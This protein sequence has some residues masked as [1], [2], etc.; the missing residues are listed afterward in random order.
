MNDL[1]YLILNLLVMF[2]NLVDHNGTLETQ[3]TLASV[4]VIFLWFK[5]FD[6]LRLFDSTAF[7]I[8]LI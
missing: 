5:V 2:M 6:W 3:R 7:F 1:T 8:K 4:S